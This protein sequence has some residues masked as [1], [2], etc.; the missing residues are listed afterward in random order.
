M[1]TFHYLQAYANERFPL[2]RFIIIIFKFVSYISSLHYLQYVQLFEN[3]R[4]NF[5]ENE[6]KWDLFH[7]F[8][9]IKLRK[10][11]KILCFSEAAI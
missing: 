10:S 3:Y 7:R 2:P 4:L 1:W 9:F 5:P 11:E 6:I 8:N